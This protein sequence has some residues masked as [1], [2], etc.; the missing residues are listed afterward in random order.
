MSEYKKIAMDMLI[1]IMYETQKHKDKLIGIL[2]GVL[3]GKIL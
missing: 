2:I 3:I 1:F